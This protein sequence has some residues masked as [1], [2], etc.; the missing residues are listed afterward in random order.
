MSIKLLTSLIPE[1]LLCNNFR[2]D[3]HSLLAIG[4]ILNHVS[5]YTRYIHLLNINF[6]TRNVSFLFSQH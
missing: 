5:S 4:H 3:S 6:N 2:K 1:E